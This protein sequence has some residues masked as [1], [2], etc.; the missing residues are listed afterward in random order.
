MASVNSLGENS[1]LT[2]LCRALHQFVAGAVHCKFVMRRILSAD[3]S[4][5]VSSLTLV[6]YM[7]AQARSGRF[8]L[9]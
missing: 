3:I 1:L 4:S 9:V 5:T 2:L 8:L 6:Q 7:D